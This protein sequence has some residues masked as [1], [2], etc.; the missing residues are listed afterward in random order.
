[1]KTIYKNKKIKFLIAGLALV[2][3]ASLG[4][5]VQ[6]CSQEDELDNITPNVYKKVE[7]CDFKNWFNSQEITN[8]VI[9]NR[10]LNWDNAELTVMP[11]GESLQVSFEIYKGKNFLGNDSI[12]ELQIACVKNSFIG[13]VEVL[14]FS[15]KEYAQYDY[16]NLRGQILE[17]GIYYAPNQV[18][19]SL[20]RYAAEDVG[21]RLK[22][23][24]E[25]PCSRTTTVEGS[26]PTE[27]QRDMYKNPLN[28]AHNDSVYNCHA[29]V[30]GYLKSTDP[31]YI[32][33]LPKWNENPNIAGSGCSQVSTPQVG[34]RWVSY[35]KYGNPVHSA[36]VEEVTNGKVTLLRAKCG[37]D[38]VKKYDPDCSDFSSTYPTNNVKYY[39]K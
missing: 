3:V 24:S 22:S 7:A 19:I 38:A 13:R 25:N 2:L 6:S 20:E 10:E 11:D 36:F 12:R 30:W 4:F 32:P 26:T 1:M 23:D 5:F 39:R 35:D 16:Y 29:Y 21:V 27:I 31:Y 33:N 28:S 8:G 37:Q 14:S 34:D 15:S 17:E 9:G 18:H